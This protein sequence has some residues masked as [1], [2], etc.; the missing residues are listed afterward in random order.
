MADMY[1]DFN[2]GNDANDGLTKRTPKKNL[3][4]TALN[5]NVGA[6]N[7][8]LLASDSI[9]NIAG[10]KSTNSWMSA[11][12]LN[13]AGYNSRAYLTSYDPAGNITGSKPTISYQFTP[14]SADWTWDAAISAWYIQ[15]GFTISQYDIWA[16]LNGNYVVNV[17]QNNPYTGT[18]ATDA[19]RLKTTFNGMTDSMYRVWSNGTGNRLYFWGPGLDNSSL[20]PTQVLGAGSFVT[21]SGPAIRLFECGK[22]LTVDG[23]RTQYGSGLLLQASGTNDIIMP[24]L[25]V[26]NCETFDTTCSFETSITN[27]DTSTAFV[28]HQLHDNLFKFTAGWA[29]KTYGRGVTGDAYFNEMTD[30]NNCY[31]IGGTVYHGSRPPLNSN[32]GKTLRNN[33]FRRAKNGVS[34]A[35]FDGCAIYSDVPDDATYAYGNL[36]TEC[37]RAAQVNSGRKFTFSG[38]IALNCDMLIAGNDADSV[39]Q[40]D[41]RVNNNLL[42]NTNLTTWPR[43]TQAQQVPTAMTLRSN[44]NNSTSL[45]LIEC[46]NNVII[47]QNT[48]VNS[49]GIR[50]GYT[51]NWS[52]IDAGTNYVTG[53]GTAI[54]D[55]GSDGSTGIADKTAYAFTITGGDPGFMAAASGDFR[56]KADSILRGAG[57]P[58][59]EI[60]RDFYSLNFDIKR[61]SIGAIEYLDLDK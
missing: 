54:Q 37:F 60:A 38:N 35:S 59:L 58:T 46:K 4:P 24:G 47:G 25:E 12:L 42:Y 20:T 14:V 53:F 36:I 31:S 49:V 16:K 17:N 2:R 23:I 44:A 26:K 57:T 61:P 40:I 8:I 56:L 1:Y 15:F 22:Y 55:F 3:T 6:G 7:A 48:P 32:S 52:K 5:I 11:F 21:A 33:I 41:Y 50:L 45:N 19:A 39:N 34:N 10:N 9:W 27:T 51:N 13:G 28:E 30:S 43:G 29:Y 18:P